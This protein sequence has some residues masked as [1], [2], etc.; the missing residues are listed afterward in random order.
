VAV[1]RARNSPPS[2][3]SHSPKAPESPLAIAALR[4]REYQGG[5]VE[6]IQELPGSGPFRRSLI[7]YPSDNLRITG[8]MTVPEGEGPFPVLLLCHGDIPREQYRSGDGTEDVAEHLTLAGYLTLASD[9]RGYAGSGDGVLDPRLI[10]H[11]PELAIDVLNLLASVPAVAKADPKRIGLWGHSLGGETGLRALEAD[12]E[13][14]VKATVFWAPASA[15]VNE[16]NRFYTPEETPPLPPELDHQLSPLNYVHWVSAPVSLHQGTAD[17][18]VKPEWA[19]AIRDALRQAGKQLEYFEYPGEGHNFR[20]GGWA[21]IVQR[22]TA[23]FDQ[24]VRSA[25]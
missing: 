10:H 4:A 25:P 6:V 2:D 3:S 13:R 22:T 5:P 15:V 12:D 21:D 14:R 9:H 16:N 18:E 11:R 8:V 19:A 7:A 23:F 1:A 24:H 20:A 17:T